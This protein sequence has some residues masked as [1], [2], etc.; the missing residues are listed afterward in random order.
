MTDKYTSATLPLPL[1]QAHKL[2]PG[3]ALPLAFVRK[4]GTLTPGP[5]PPKPDEPAK[6]YVPVAA[7]WHWHTDAVADEAHCL[8]W[9]GRPHDVALPYSARYGTLSGVV[10]CLSLSV[11]TLR[12]LQSCR[13]IG[14]SQAPALAGCGANRNSAPQ[15]VVHCHSVPAGISPPL[16]WCSP[17]VI[18]P[19]PPPPPPPQP[20]PP[21]P[22]RRATV[23]QQFGQPPATG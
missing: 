15:R 19:P 20:P 11:E 5:K 1:N 14:I 21:P 8:R 7:D 6:R 3:A 16:V 23:T 22:P 13:R 4:L 17:V 9:Q 12:G 2:Q 10:S 18:A